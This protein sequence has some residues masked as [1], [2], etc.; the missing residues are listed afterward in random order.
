MQQQK[1]QRPALK[2]KTGIKAGI[3]VCEEVDAGPNTAENPDA[4]P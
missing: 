2:V 1:A 3:I 4:T